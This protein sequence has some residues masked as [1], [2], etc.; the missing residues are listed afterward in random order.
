MS[1]IGWTEHTKKA[2]R[3]LDLLSGAAV[4]DLSRDNRLMALALFLWA[5]GEG[6]FIYIQPLYVQQ[7]GADPVQIGGV[8]SLAGF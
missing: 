3:L 7:L 5:S 8:L 6:L 4:T 2:R 1:K